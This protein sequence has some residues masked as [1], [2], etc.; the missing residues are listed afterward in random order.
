MTTKIIDFMYTTLTIGTL[1]GLCY[2]LADILGLIPESYK[3]RA[4]ANQV[5]SVTFMA[6]VIMTFTIVMLGSLFYT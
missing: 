5:I 6:I 3:V 1:L 2:M 4:T